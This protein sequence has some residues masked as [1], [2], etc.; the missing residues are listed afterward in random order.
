MFS[1]TS[2]TLTAAIFATLATAGCDSAALYA[3]PPPPAEEITVRVFGDPE[4][5]VANV[6][7]G[8]GAGVLAKTDATGTAR[9]KLDGA[10]GTRFDLAVTC[11]EG[12]G[13]PP[14]PL[15]VVLRRGSRAPEYITSC[16][17]GVRTAVVA[18]R[19]PGAAGM[20]VLHLGREISRL[21]EQGMSLVNL[22][23]KVGETFSLSLDTT[24]TKYKFLRP[25]NPEVSFSVADADELF[26]YEPKFNEERPIVARARVVG[27]YVPRKLE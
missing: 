22:D 15:K 5:P 26:T 6:D 23:V 17:R 19:A 8:S 18:I 11:P 20:P 25:Q 2:A 13:G 21:D 16:K 10:D 1:R 9:F 24:D 12:F 3:P 7:I 27:P 14:R 4:E